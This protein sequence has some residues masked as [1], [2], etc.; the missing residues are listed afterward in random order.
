MTRLADQALF[1]LLGGVSLEGFLNAA[2]TLFPPDVLVLVPNELVVFQAR[3]Q[4]LMS[5]K[6]LL[7]VRVHSFGNLESRLSEERWPDL[8][9]PWEVAFFLNSLAPR[10]RPFLELPEQGS[11]SEN[12][13]LAAQLADGFDRLRLAGLTWEDVEQA[14]PVALAKALAEL[15]R[16]Y[17]SWLADRDDQFSR[18]LKIIQALENRE[19]FRFLRG[20]DRV[21]CFHSQRLSPFETKLLKALA[22]S[23]REVVIKLEV[24]DWLFEDYQ[25]QSNRGFQRLMAIE[26]FES[27]GLDNLTLDF[28]DPLDSA[29]SGGESEPSPLA[30]AAHHLFGPPAAVPPPPVGEAIRIFQAPSRYQEVEAVARELK[31][32]LL[33]GVPPAQLAALVPNLDE[34]LADFLDVGR[35]FGLEFFYRQGESLAKAGPV[36]AITDLLALWSSQWELGRVLRTLQSP[37]FD[38]GLGEIPLAEILTSG[39]SDDRAGGGFEVNV[40]KAIRQGQDQLGPVLEVVQALREA[41]RRLTSETTWPLFLA[42]FAQILSQWGWPNLGQPLWPANSSPVDREVQAGYAQ[43]LADEPV[44]A[45]LFQEAL[46]ELARAVANSVD[47]PEPSLTSFTF[48][49][50]KFLSRRAPLAQSSPGERVWLLNYYDAHGTRFKK[51]FLMGLSEGVFPAARAEARWWPDE[52]VRSLAKSSLGRSL[53]TEAVEGYRQGEE[54]FAAALGQAESVVLTFPEKSSDN[55][56]KPLLPSP[57]IES[58]RSLWPKDPE[59][60]R[61]TIPIEAVGARLELADLRDPGELA[62]FLAE[63]NLTPPPEL[64]ASL[65]SP[66]P[67]KYWNSLARRRAGLSR[68][69]PELR[70]ETI[71]KWVKNLPQL[72]D[73]PLLPLKPLSVYANCSLEFWFKFILELKPAPTPGG[74]W[75]FFAQGNLAH[76]VLNEFFLPLVKPKEKPDLS[77]PR[78]AEIFTVFAKNL[79][80]TS[81]IGREPLFETSLENIRRTLQK[82]HER[83]ENLAAT[84]IKALEW[85]FGYNPREG[86][87]IPPGPALPIGA[88]PGKF[89]LRGRVDRIDQVGQELVIRDYKLRHSAK[90]AKKTKVGSWEEIEG[91]PVGQ[92]NILLYLL[93]VK[94]H[95]KKPTQ[96]VFE[97]LNPSGQEPQSVVEIEPEFFRRFLVELWQGLLAGQARKAKDCGNCEFGPVCPESAAEKI[98][99]SEGEE[100]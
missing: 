64:L 96:A 70:P 3:Q 41:G 62:L 30:Y 34:Y 36:Q 74:E 42:T 61:P 31:K 48:W 69:K 14:P 81:P 97:F 65:P 13:E 11:L 32:E 54:I 99:E 1:E 35:R 46:D 53:W 21:C 100:G 88:G 83:Q 80:E 10:L 56:Q 22:R 5:R 68:P 82:W 45:R 93:A 94:D 24:P 60:R 17:E 2:G 63:K 77:W 4:A 6:V 57:V 89:Y 59:T 12:A 7:N 72:V 79:R 19:E 8:V 73:G 44:A 52:L 37:Y 78:L 27:S 91:V 49:L 92:Y 40:S 75:D 95:F 66:E 67:E 90:I 15:G 16:A 29:D 38:F 85:S 76:G 39:A 50:S 23:G 33:A 98:S 87:L 26:D 71:A 25:R 28:V 47:A 43:A 86:Q 58:L 20:L 18:R 84:K 9:S 55:R 51:L